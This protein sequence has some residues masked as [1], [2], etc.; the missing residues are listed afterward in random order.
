MPD[1]AASSCGMRLNCGMQWEVR[2]PDGRV[3][4]VGPEGLAQGTWRAC[5]PAAYDVALG[6]RTVRVVV[7]EGPDDRGH[8]RFTVDG[9]A[10]AVQA[11]DARSLLLE[12]MGM[13]E[14]SVAQDQEVRAPMP[15]KVLSVAVAAGTAVRE[16]DAV[17]VLE[18]MKMENVIRS[19]RAG[20]VAGVSVQPGQAVE[21]GAVLLTYEDA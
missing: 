10:V 15:G 11:V 16:G 2:W 8:L 4:S 14:A 21:K 1:T 17:A 13:G 9:V 3:V 6:D 20:V 19:P 18:A 5:G 12:R 7:L